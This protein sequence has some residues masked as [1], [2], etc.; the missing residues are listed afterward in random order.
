MLSIC[1]KYLKILVLIFLLSIPASVFSQDVELDT[2]INITGPLS[3]DDQ[4]ELNQYLMMAA[5]SGQT[6]VMRWLIRN[7]AEVDSKTYQNAT[8]LMFAVANNNLEA[9]KTLLQYKPDVNIFTTNSETPLL[10][11]A[12]NGNLEIAEALIRDSADINF[13]DIHGATPLHYASIYGYFYLTDMLLYYNA[14]NDIKSKDGNTPL[15][16]AIWSGFADI[17][18][19]LIQNGANCGEKDNQGF[20][21]LMIA[22]QNGDTIIMEILLKKQVNIYEINN[23]YYD[24]LDISIRSNQKTATEYLLRHGYKG[25][26]KLPETISPYTVA[27]KYS[28]AEITNLLKKNGILEN[29]RFGFDQVSFSISAKLSFHDYYT[30][31]NIVFK[32]P[33]LNGGIIA[34]IDFKPDYTRVLMKVNDDTYNQYFDKSSIVYGGVFK[35]IPVTDRPYGGNWIFTSSLIGAYEFGNKLKGTNIAPGNKFKI[36]PAVGF[37]WISNNFSLS[38]NLEYMKSEFYKIG[39][40]WI[41]LG[42]AYNIYLDNYRAPGKAIKWY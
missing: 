16:A 20:T 41:R 29:R 21:P 32:E 33:V 39:P 10:A 30:G 24:A 19:I 35:D 27:I 2:T 31:A 38:G 42:I 26:K 28:R 17:A 13:A 14:T 3:S 37:R 5:T 25:E 9:V 36:I 7:G 34:G 18:D 12:K 15:M 1:N 11:A 6:E 8:P 4:A 40:V 22:A 23:F